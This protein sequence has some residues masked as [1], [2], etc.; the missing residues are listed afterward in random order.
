MPFIS[1]HPHLASLSTVPFP[2]SPAHGAL[3]F[4]PVRYALDNLPKHQA[5]EC[6]KSFIAFEKQHGDR[7][8][9]EDVIVSKRRFQYEEQVKEHPLNYDAW[10]DYVRLEESTG[11]A[12]RVREVCQ[13]A[14][15]P[16]IDR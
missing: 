13:R 2:Q 12:D 3:F 4:A 9:I 5:Q 8:G 16:C 14:A 10:F 15:A 6:Y 1:K 7:D 11:D